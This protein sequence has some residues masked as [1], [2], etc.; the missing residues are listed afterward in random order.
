MAASP[1]GPA[2]SAGDVVQGLDDDRDEQALD[3]VAGQ[4]DQRVRGGVAGVFVR[5][6]HGQEGVGEHCQGDPAAPRGIAADLVLIESGQALLGLISS[7]RPATLISRP[8]REWLTAP[9]WASSNGSRPVRRQ[10]CC[11]GSAAGDGLGGHRQ[12]R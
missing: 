5:A 4:R 7:P 8:A 12:D 10:C 11:G 1:V 2:E 6:D 3:L 9:N